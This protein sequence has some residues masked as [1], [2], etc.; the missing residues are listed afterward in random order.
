MFDIILGGVILVVF[1]LLGIDVSL[2]I[3]NKLRARRAERET[4]AKI[5]EFISM[6][7]EM[8]KEMTQSKPQVVR[9]IVV[10]PTEFKSAKVKMPKNFGK[11]EEQRKAVQRERMR[12]YRAK[13]RKST[14]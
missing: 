13:K 7:E 1:V 5:G 3:Q 11:T 10:K 6:M 12:K 14:K 4:R 8:E 9:K 2:N